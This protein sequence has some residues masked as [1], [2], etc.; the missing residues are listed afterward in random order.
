M[1]KSFQL[2]L[3]MGKVVALPVPQPL[4]DALQS[5]QITSAAGG[6]SGFQLTFAVSRGSVITKTLL[7]FALLD[8]PT[9]VVL[10]TIIGGSLE[11]L[12]DGVLTR[13]EMS[14]GDAPGSSTLT[15]TGED[16]TALMDLRH[17]QQSYPG[18]PIYVQVLRI[19]KGYAQYGIAPAA[20][21]PKFVEPY[22]P[23]DNY[24][25]QAGTDLS[26]LRAL[27]RKA[28][29]AFYLEPGPRPGVSAAYWGPEVRTGKPQPA[30]TVDS[31]PATNVE[32]M[33][34]GFD[35]TA[36]T[37]FTIRKEEPTT[38]IGISIPVPNLSLLRPPL[39]SRPA[40]A[41]KEQPLPDLAGLSALEVLLKGLSRTEAASDAVTGQGKL[42]VLRYGHVLKARRLVGVR[43]AGL[44]YDGTYYVTR[45]THEIKRGEYTQS[46][47]LTRDAF[48]PF[49]PQRV[50]V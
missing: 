40:V 39:A 41:L 2:L 38:K 4:V 3:M 49:P 8:P 50:D 21:P 24:L 34:F 13:Q 47:S 25:A 1:A 32:S 7:P 44:D 27:A 30:L 14:P 33:S 36:R 48:V 20:I 26:Y 9:R 16:L 45:V 42:D 22:L 43:G 28:G 12:M 29:Y 46:F 31:G 11:V 35:G 15:V 19:L 10:A 18:Q 6:P 17:V 5:V 23:E 37:Q